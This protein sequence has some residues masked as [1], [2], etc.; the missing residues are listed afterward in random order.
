[1]T[2]TTCSSCSSPLPAV[3]ADQRRPD[4]CAA[5]VARSSGAVPP[6]TLPPVP[7]WPVGPGAPGAPPMG[8]GTPAALVTR[9]RVPDALLL[10]IAA[11]AIAG[12]AWWA[13]VATTKTTFTY[14]AIA[15]GILVGQAV[16]IG[17]RKGG[18]VPALIAVAASLTALVV[19]EYFIQRTVAINDFNANVPL[20]LGFSTAKDIVRE[21]V[22][23]EPLTAVFWGVAAVAA[24]LSAG[25]RTR[26][27]IL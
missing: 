12:V 20:W 14:G 24:A 27:P 25:S 1:M 26:R 19:A 17:A 9:T 11:A 23:D 6:S 16:L 10:G 22:E 13:V 7:S 8:Y 18:V 5:C 15:V 2:P 4:L 21:A 3:A